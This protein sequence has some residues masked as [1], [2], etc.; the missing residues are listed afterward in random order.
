[1]NWRMSA[2][3]LMEVGMHQ[4]KQLAALAMVPFSAGFLLAQQPRSETKTT[5][6]TTTTWN[7]TLI[8]AGCRATHTEQKETKSDEN[9]AKSEITRTE[10]VDCPA[11][12][13][14]QS[15]GLLTADGKY[16]QFDPSSNTKIVQ[17]VKSN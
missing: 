7:G 17:V 4:F 6:T 10:K 9:G 11:M 8:D 13:T 2:S 15:F 3:A 1:M 16:V 14:T 5:T 12:S